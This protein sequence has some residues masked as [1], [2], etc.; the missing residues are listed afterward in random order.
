MEDKTV[1]LKTRSGDT[2]VFGRIIEKYQSRLRGFAARYVQDRNDVF[3][4]VQD[5]FLNALKNLDT[6]DAEKRFYPWVRAICLN[7]I[8]NFFR[9]RK[10]KRAC[11]LSVVD[12]AIEE[13]LFS[14]SEER[15]ESKDRIKALM[16]CMG[17]LKDFHRN[18]IQLRYSNGMAVKNIAEKY[19]KTA[20]AVSM[21]ILR[22]KK[23]LKECLDQQLES[24]VE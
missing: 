24:G 15:E 10:T 7:R 14:M 6:F 21:A 23:S 11:S 17:K 16:Y 20:D 12:E 8:R 4:I 13:R 5:A 9:E 19:K 22:I 2:R 18:I 3:D 1:I